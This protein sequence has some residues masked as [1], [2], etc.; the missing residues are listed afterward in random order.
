M[1]I[2]VAACYGMPPVRVV[3]VVGIRYRKYTKKVAD[4]SKKTENI[5]SAIL[6]DGISRQ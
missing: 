2:F 1:G 6:E 3:T 5:A 4:A